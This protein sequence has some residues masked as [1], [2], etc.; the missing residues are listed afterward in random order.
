[1]CALVGVG[2][3]RHLGTGD[4]TDFDYPEE[5]ERNTE[6]V[7]MAVTLGG[8]R[9]YLEHT[10]L[11]RYPG[12]RGSVVRLN[13]LFPGLELETTTSNAGQPCLSVPPDAGLLSR[14]PDLERAALAR[15]IEDVAP[16]IKELSP[17][18]ID[19]NFFRVRVKGPR[20]RSR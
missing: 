14:Q 12:Q 8:Q 10:L 4:P 5:W 3:G 18:T 1:L 9:W 16:A 7:E 15:W 17:A 20:S 13:R 19:R 6:A 11:E 2:L